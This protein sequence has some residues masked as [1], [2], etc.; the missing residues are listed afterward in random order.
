MLQ[1]QVGNALRSLC[2]CISRESTS[3]PVSRQ[4]PVLEVVETLSH[5]HFKLLIR[6]LALHSSDL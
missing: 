2:C 5:R 1:G 6:L 4:T 3:L